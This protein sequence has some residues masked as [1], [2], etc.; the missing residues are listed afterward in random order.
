MPFPWSGIRPLSFSWKSWSRTEE[1]KEQAKWVVD[2]IKNYGLNKTNLPI[3]FDWESWEKFEELGISI[4]ELNH[5][6]QVF[7]TE[8]ENAG[9]EGALYSSTN[10]MDRIWLDEYVKNVWIASYVTK[11]NYMGKYFMWQYTNKGKIDGINGDVDLNI[12]YI[13]KY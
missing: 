3:C 6:A 4:Y 8:I 1:A 13:N 2:K 9:Y 5:V 7:N 11:T 10:Y 12:L